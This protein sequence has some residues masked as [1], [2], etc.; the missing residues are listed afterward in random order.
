MG[1]S[2][3][4]RPVRR[5]QLITIAAGLLLTAALYFGMTTVPP[6]GAGRSGGKEA[7]HQAGMG[8]GPHIDAA[9]TETILADARR[10]LP[11]HGQAE[12]RAAEARLSGLRDSVQMAPVFEAVSKVWAEHGALEAAAYY[13]ALSARLEKSPEKLNF[14]GQFF[15]NLMHRPAADS[16]AV[17]LWEAE[18]AVASLSQALQIAP[19]DSTRLALASGYIDGTGE[20]MQG[21]QLLL[22]IVRKD[23][24]HIPAN[25]VLGKL[26]VQSGQWDKAISRF[27]TILRQ[28]PRNTEALYF[29]AEAYK[30]HGD[31]QQA[32]ETFE[33]L[34][35]L[36]NNPD[37]SRDV[38]AYLKTF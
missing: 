4:C 29:L 7:P 6:A 38:D 12:L 33:R 20:T 25:L 10:S 36:V 27:Q 16:P 23:P 28:E 14:A 17:R 13:R 15:L 35:P 32:V 18:Q 21:V 37:F 9:R 24:G 11:V 3:L 1:K 30:G 8:S 22:G 2:Y 34:K 31:R 5:P 26:A 19:A